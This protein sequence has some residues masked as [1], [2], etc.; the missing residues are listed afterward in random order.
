MGLRV[1]MI[2]R[3]R[4]SYA[5][6]IGCTTQVGEK[7]LSEQRIGFGTKVATRGTY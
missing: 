3:G 7:G 5:V 2:S 4:G 6:R 1:A